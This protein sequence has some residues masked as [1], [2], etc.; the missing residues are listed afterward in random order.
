MITVVV[1]EH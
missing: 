1:W